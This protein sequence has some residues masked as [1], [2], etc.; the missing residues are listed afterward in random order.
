[1]KVHIKKTDNSNN[2]SIVIK[3]TYY[4]TSHPYK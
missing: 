3:A 2:I 4:S 1:M